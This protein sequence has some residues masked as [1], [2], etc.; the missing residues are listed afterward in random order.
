M[1]YAKFV[2]L[3]TDGYNYHAEIVEEY[4]DP[5]FCTEPMIEVLR[6]GPSLGNAALP[7]DVRAARW[8]KEQGLAYRG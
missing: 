7:A 5:D 1:S 6:V 8:A 3:G 2:R 4:D